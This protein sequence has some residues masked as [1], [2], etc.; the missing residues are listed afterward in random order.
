MLMVVGYS[1]GDS[2]DA[3]ARPLEPLAAAPRLDRALV[4]VPR[5]RTSVAEL[6][7]LFDQIAPEGKR[8]LA[9][10]LYV[11]DQSCPQLWQDAEV[12]FKSLPSPHSAVWLLPAV[13]W[14]EHPNAALEIPE[15]INF[16]VFAAY[17]DGADD[18]AMRTWHTD[19]IGRIEPHSN[20]VGYVGDADLAVHPIAVLQPE[21]A[22]R[23]ETLR[24]KY[25]PQRRFYSYPRELPLARA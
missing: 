3:A 15:Q 2:V 19:A 18:E 5:G 8:Y 23:L 20:G 10:N 16:G 12:V 21:C 7:T 13:P 1:F 25:D 14:D 6:Y 9:D 4:H 17:D 24:D 22:Q 11:R